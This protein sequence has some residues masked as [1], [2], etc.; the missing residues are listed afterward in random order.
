MDHLFSLLLFLCCFF[1][2]FSSLLF[3]LLN[4][5]KRR[6]IYDC[7]VSTIGSTGFLFLIAVTVGALLIASTCEALAVP[8]STSF[9]LFF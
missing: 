9:L 8:F 7:W 6:K 4:K 2:V 3:G 1:L 5:N